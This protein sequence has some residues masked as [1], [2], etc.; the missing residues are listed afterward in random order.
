MATPKPPSH[1][2]ARGGKLTLPPP[3]GG[4]LGWGLEELAIRLSFR[5]K[6]DMNDCHFEPKARNLEFP[7]L[8]VLSGKGKA[9]ETANCFGSRG[10]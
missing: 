1:P 6:G 7:F 3:T 8:P 4:G 2:P 9:A 10:S 5:A